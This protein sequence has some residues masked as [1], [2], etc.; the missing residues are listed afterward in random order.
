[1]R[2]A[3]RAVTRCKKA[4]ADLAKAKAQGERLGEPYAEVGFRS[5][6]HPKQGCYIPWR[7]ITMEGPYTRILGKLHKAEAL[8]PNHRD[9]RLTLHN[10]QYHLAVAFNAERRKSE[11]Q[12]R[13]VALDPGIRT[14]LT[15]FSETDAG[16]IGKHDF[17][18]IQR[19]CQHLDQLISRTA[20]TGFR[21]KRNLRKAADR[22]RVRNNEPHQRASPPGRTLPGRQLRPH[23]PANI[24]NQR[25]GATRERGKIRSKSAT[26]HADLRP[27]PI[28]AVST[29]E[30]H[31][32]QAKQVLLV[33]EAYHQQNLQLE[34]GDQ[35]PSSEDATLDPELRR[36]PRRTRHQRRPWDIPAGFGRYPLADAISVH[37]N[38]RC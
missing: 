17:G 10:G 33:N 35:S 18:R 34:R 36:R 8:P 5:C 11:T 14:F 3:C 24:R 2:D 30:G 6:K 4:N 1:M 12:A 16:Q 26:L 37:R 29:V 21:R 28:P 20:K 19:L 32:R 25:H 27:L 7:S 9:G 38:R 15:W 31:G 22:M 13:V 23:P